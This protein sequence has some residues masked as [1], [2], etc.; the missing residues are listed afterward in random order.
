L[1]RRWI[2]PAWRKDDVMDVKTEG[3]PGTSV[4]R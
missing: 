1:L 2:Q 3:A 4:N